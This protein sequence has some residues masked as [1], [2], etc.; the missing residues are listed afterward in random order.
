MHILNRVVLL[1]LLS[2]TLQ[3]CS[4]R[5]EAPLEP[6]GQTLDRSAQQANDAAQQRQQQQ[7]QQTPQPQPQP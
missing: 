6:S 5:K 2:L 4:D 3:A 1:A 7:Q